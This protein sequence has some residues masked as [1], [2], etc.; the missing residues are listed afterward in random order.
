MN[1]Q[2]GV[3]LA[4]ERLAHTAEEAERIVKDIGASLCLFSLAPFVTLLFVP[5]YSLLHT[6]RITLAPFLLPLASYT[7]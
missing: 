3:M 5:F 7:Y 4:R 1:I 6:P 2:E